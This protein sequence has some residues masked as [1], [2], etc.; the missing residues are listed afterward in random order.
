MSGPPQHAARPAAVR[1]L[2]EQLAA[3]SA[4]P[5]VE[6]LLLLA[7]LL[8]FLALSCFIHPTNDDFEGSVL[9]RRLGMAESV[10]FYYLH[11]TG[12]YTSSLLYGLV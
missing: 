12:R 8:P 4:S 10:Q 3:W 11:W 1:R 2:S 7:G 5:A 6:G 9:A